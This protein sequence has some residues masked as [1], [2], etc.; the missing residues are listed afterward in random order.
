MR[1]RE[2]G[3]CASGQMESGHFD[4]RWCVPPPYCGQTE[5]SS[6]GFKDAGAGDRTDL[7]R[8]AHFQESGGRSTHFTESGGGQTLGFDDSRSGR[9]ARDW[10]V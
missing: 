1:F 2:N 10:D 8:S 4:E 9:S 7:S 3:F 5:G 6:L